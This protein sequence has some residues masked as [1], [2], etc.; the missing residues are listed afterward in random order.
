M[1]AEF[2][3]F[4]SHAWADGEHPWR[5][6]DALKSAGLHVWFDAYEI[7]DF[8]SIT[9]AVTD[10]VARSK[11]LLA[12]YSKTY[13]LRRA[14]QWEMT[15]AFL[16][17]Q[18][19]GDP[20]RRILVINPEEKADHIHPIELRDVKLRAAPTNV[21][22]LDELVQSVA[23]HVAGI[24]GPLAD[25]HPLAAPAWHGR[26]LVSSTHFV[27]RVAEMWHVHSLLHARDVVQITGAAPA[28]VVAISG[29]AGVGKSLMAEEYALRFGSGYPGGIFWISVYRGE[30]QFAEQTRAIAE[31]LGIQTRGKTGNEIRGALSRNIGRVGEACLWI[32]DDVPDELD[33]DTLRRWFAPQPLARTLI[34]TRSREYAAFTKGIDLLA[35]SPNDA[36]QLLTSRRKPDCIREE[37]QARGLAKDLGFHSLALD[38]TASAVVSSASAQPF[39]DF[40]AKL[41]RPDKDALLLAE[42]LADAL[43]NG[44]QKSIAQTM[45]GGIQNLQAEGLDF[46]R[47]ASVLAV[48]PITASLVAAVSEEADQLSREDAEERTSLAFKQVT[49][50]SLA[51]IAGEKQNARSV[52]TL[53]S[54]AV[55]FQEK[56]V[57]S[58]REALRKAA[59]KAIRS[60]ILRALNDPEP[61]DQ[62]TLLFEHARHV[63]VN[64]AN[65]S[66][67]NFLSWVSNCDYVQGLY[68]S[69]RTLRER[70]L[71]FRLREQGPEHP[72]TLANM[73]NLALVLN[74]Q[75]DYATARRLQEQVIETRTRVLGEG[76]PRSLAAMNDLAETLRAQGEYPAA[77]VLQE[78]VLGMMT[79]VPVGEDPN[80]LTVMNNLAMTLLAQGDAVEA[81]ALEERVFE[82]KLRLLGENDPETL[83]S[84]H[85]LA[86]I[87]R[88][89]GDYVGA[90]QLQERVSLALARELGANHPRTLVSLEVL[91][92][93][94]KAQ[95]DH[96]GARQLEE[97]VMQKRTLLLG[98]DHPQTLRSMWKIGL[99][100]LHSGE[101]TAGI[102]MLRRCLTLRRKVLGD[103]DP[104][105]IAAREFLTRL[106]ADSGSDNVR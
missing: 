80:A 34:T 83:T 31:S 25:I 95:G 92:S 86:L 22:A 63:V 46:L 72:H 88:A 85:N 91:A 13:P 74:E 2:D 41:S 61:R 1:A 96:A 52:H 21:T 98:E 29:L 12:Y 40:R 101:K 10:G 64:P 50:A 16:A 51:E 7:G 69:A 62:I 102:G 43:P 47:L 14:C 75:E 8:R 89:Q 19:E 68:A 87:I 76:H 94:V 71:E 4:L 54:R 39:G 44:H 38:V 93:I 106:K 27:G 35:L 49:S 42:K 65:V 26:T 37:E 15:T 79:N 104:E 84:M 105:T 90:R 33:G 32:L 97:R 67:A 11:V 73:S 103:Q 20:G 100:L 24:E 57:L 48:A 45:L 18:T 60:E 17:A 82:A 59:V 5:I 36:V 3:V 6:A 53:V 30:A 77:R 9:R 55:H 66:E 99:A 28:G 23:Q 56:H 58:R 81:R 70:E 78:R